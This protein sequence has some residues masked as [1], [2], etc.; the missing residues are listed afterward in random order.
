MAALLFENKGFAIFRI[1]E[2]TLAFICDEIARCAPAF[3]QQ[4]RSAP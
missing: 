2:R 4:E 1:A 3:D